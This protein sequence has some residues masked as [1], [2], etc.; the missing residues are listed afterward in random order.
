MVQ[1]TE[2]VRQ[3]LDACGMED[4]TAIWAYWTK[5]GY[6]RVEVINRG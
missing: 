4:V 2:T 6:Y 5:E 1:S 3:R